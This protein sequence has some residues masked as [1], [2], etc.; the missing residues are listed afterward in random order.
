MVNISHAFAKTK[1]DNYTTQKINYV[2]QVNIMNQYPF[3]NVCMCNTL[4]KNV[5]NK[6][7]C[8]KEERG[9]NIFTQFA[10]KIII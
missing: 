2:F 7:S 8:E 1:I 5:T 9:D 10:I 3:M 6:E 4:I